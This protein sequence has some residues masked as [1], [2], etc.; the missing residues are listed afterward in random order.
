[1]TKN[2]FDNY[3]RTNK[4]ANLLL[5]VM[6]KRHILDRPKLTV[7]KLATI[8]N[9]D[10][11]TVKKVVD[12][13][14]DVIVKE[15]KGERDV[16]SLN[17]TGEYFSFIK[18]EFKNLID[19]PKEYEAYSFNQC[20][21]SLD[22]LPWR[23][24][25]PNEKELKLLIVFGTTHSTVFEHP[26]SISDALWVPEIS[27][28]LAKFAM[29]MGVRP[30][31][32]RIEC[33]LDSDIHEGKISEDDLSEFNILCTGST[34]VNS[35]LHEVQ[36]EVGPSLYA[37]FKDIP[38]NIMIATHPEREGIGSQPILYEYLD[39]KKGRFSGVFQLLAN[40]YAKKQQ[41]DE[42]LI[43]L[44]YGLTRHG[45]IAALKTLYCYL[46]TALYRRPRIKDAYKGGC[47]PM[48]LEGKFPKLELN[49]YVD[50][51]PAKIVCGI[52][53]ASPGYEDK[54]LRLSRVEFLE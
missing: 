24:L 37:E 49:S 45:T 4:S 5:R 29:K 54:R 51:V 2:A 39:S 12:E 17:E 31:D 18:S 47:I 44:T 30:V 3:V 35:L 15:S 42:R 14:A 1:L 40:H 27:S 43:I 48:E 46:T 36:L 7:G 26:A 52:I 10:R 13:F 41:K 34:A 6:L 20:M 16:Y 22:D 53:E 50:M 8:T 11:R 21:I 9:L 38:R 25:S 28:F 23:L 32:I 33:C 19:P